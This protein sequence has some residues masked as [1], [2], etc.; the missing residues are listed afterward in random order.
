MSAQEQ[1]LMLKAQEGDPEAAAALEQLKAD[2]LAKLQADSAAQAAAAA[3]ASLSSADKDMLWRPVI[4]QLQQFGGA[5][6]IANHSL[7][8]IFL[9]GI[10]GGLLAL[11]MPCI[12]P[13]IPM[14]VSFFLKRSKDNKARKASEMPSLMASPSSSSTSP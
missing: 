1:A 14:T 4:K 3:S 8:Y 11:V 2:S 12:W 10:V 9:M 13:I 7:L 5:G 6:D